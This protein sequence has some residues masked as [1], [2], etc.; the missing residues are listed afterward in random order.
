LSEPGEP[1]RAE[2][3]GQAR[4]LGSISYAI[5][6]ASV[7]LAT[8]GVALVF[9]L[10]PHLRPDPRERLAAEVQ[11][12]AI[13][14]VVTFDQFLHRQN[15]EE[16]DYGEARRETLERASGSR[17]RAVHESYAGI[18]EIPGEVVYVQVSIEGFKRRSAVLHRSLYNANSRHRLAIDN[19]GGAAT[20]RVFLEAPTDR[21]VVPIWVPPPPGGGKYFVRVELY[22]R[23][24]CY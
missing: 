22:T 15:P 19:L 1:H 17:D 8:A 9:Q 3:T 13:D 21:F 2:R 4:R 16:V 6:T 20:A 10:W 12:V 24:E 18:L 11:I 5:A 14:E 7:A 23:D